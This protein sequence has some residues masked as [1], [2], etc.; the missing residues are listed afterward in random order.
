MPRP[1][2][3]LLGVYQE[4]KDRFWESDRLLRV[5]R[6][7]G[8]EVELGD[9]SVSRLHAEIALCEAGWVVRDLGSTNGTLL[10]GARLGRSYHQL[11]VHDILQ[12]GN[13]VLIVQALVGEQCVLS[14]SR[15]DGLQVQATAEQTWEE[16]V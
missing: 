10:N 14:E 4:F 5:G 12:F 11:G 2:V 3:R 1:C 13:V 16:A 15:T 7:C 9:S 8:V 6:S